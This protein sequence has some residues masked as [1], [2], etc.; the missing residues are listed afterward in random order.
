MNNTD[1]LQYTVPVKKNFMAGTH[2]IIFINGSV[3]Q[4]IKTEIKNCFRT[5]ISF[6]GSRDKRNFKIFLRMFSAKPGVSGNDGSSSE[7]HL[8]F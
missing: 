2:Y 3:P 4:K 5:F 1:T 7:A 6:T 8:K